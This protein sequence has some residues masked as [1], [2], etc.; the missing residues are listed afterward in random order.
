MA[1]ILLHIAGEDPVLCE[2]ETLPATADV[3]ITVKNPTPA[4]WKGC[5][6]TL[7]MV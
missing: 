4:G 1:M 6:L 5:S 2:V 7:K 3:T